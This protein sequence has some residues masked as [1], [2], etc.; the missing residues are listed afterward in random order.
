MANFTEKSEQLL[1]NILSRQMDLEE[2]VQQLK[3]NSKNNFSSDRETEN[4]L[5]SIL[6]GEL[7]FSF[8]YYGKPHANSKDDVG[9]HTS[10]DKV[11]CLADVGI[12]L[13][14]EKKLSKDLRLFIIKRTNIIGFLFDRHRYSYFIH[15]D[16]I[17]L[18]V[19]SYSDI[20]QQN[21]NDFFDNIANLYKILYEVNANIE[22]IVI[23][24]IA[25][26]K[27]GYTSNEG[28]RR[29]NHLKVSRN[30]ISEKL[31][32]LIDLRNFVK[33]EFATVRFDQSLSSRQPDS[34]DL[35]V[36]ISNYV[37]SSEKAYQGVIS[38]NDKNIGGRIA[39]IDTNLEYEKLASSSGKY[40]FNPPSSLHFEE[41]NDAE[42]IF[43][44]ANNE[45]IQIYSITIT[46]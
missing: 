8:L 27:F 15:Q 35:E 12:Y 10:I 34:S 5:K 30:E 14:T 46:K 21:S 9:L 41:I 17:K 43:H 6:D 20:Q 18:F 3:R 45:N 16:K 32:Q 29:E 39:L 38:I 13:A 1:A 33:K 40:K 42:N 2:I 44:L 28:Q 37:K 4:R 31:Y 24:N 23:E 22:E 7:S 25:Y 11:Q 36:T 26:A 19:D